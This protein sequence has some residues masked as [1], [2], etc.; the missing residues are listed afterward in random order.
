MKPSP[1]LLAFVL[2][3]SCG[4]GKKEA[5]D[6]LA[7]SDSTKVATGTVIDLASFDVPFQVEL[8]D[9]TTLGI[10]TPEVRWNEEF[11]HLEVNAGEHFG[12]IITEEPADIARLK[13]DLD[14]DML[15]KHTVI[16]ETPEKL[17]YRSQFPDEDLVFIHMYQVVRAGEREFV[18][19]DRAQGRFNEADIARMCAAVRAQRPV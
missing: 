5:A 17:V 15:R 12:L 2:L 8:G 4:D 10:D 3:A 6:Q 19:E 11:G 14:R 13:A 7:T 9:L 16:E 1:F 18:L